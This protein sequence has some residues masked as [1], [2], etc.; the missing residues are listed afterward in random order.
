MRSFILHSSDISECAGVECEVH[1]GTVLCPFFTDLSKLWGNKIFAPID[2]WKLQFFLGAELRK[3]CVGRNECLLSSQINLSPVASSISFPNKR[4]DPSALKSKREI[5]IDIKGHWIGPNEGQSQ[6]G[7]S[8]NNS[9]WCTWPTA[10]NQPLRF[11]ALNT[12]NCELAN[13]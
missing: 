3:A 6:P 10:T 1:Q 9:M 5:L 8:K 12:A 4:L 7:T 11:Q 2:V 13:N